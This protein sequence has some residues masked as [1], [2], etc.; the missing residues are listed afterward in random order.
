M[1]KSDLAAHPIYHYKC[2]SIEAHLILV[3]VVLVV[4]RHLEGITGV[5]IK[6]LVKTLRRYRIIQI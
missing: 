3:F 4:A 1:S 2:D 5:T 6:Q